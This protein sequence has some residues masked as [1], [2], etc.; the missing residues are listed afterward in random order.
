MSLR[1]FLFCVMV[2]IVLMGMGV[3]V[4]QLPGAVTTGWALLILG[5][6]LIGASVVQSSWAKSLF[7]KAD[8]VAEK[9]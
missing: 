3:V 4:L 9:G 8:L 6:V 7:L 1:T 5:G 2:S